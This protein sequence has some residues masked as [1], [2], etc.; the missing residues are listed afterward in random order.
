MKKLLQKLVFYAMKPR[1]NRLL[2]KD[3]LFIAHRGLHNDIYPENSIG[4]FTNAINNN[5][6]I[7]LDV[8]KTKDD[9]LVVFHDDSL[10]RM[11][12]VNQYIEKCTYDELQKFYLKNTNYK[13]PLFEDV[14]KL[15]DGK[16][17]LIIEV[18]DQKLT[19][20]KKVSELVAEMLKNYNGEFLIE[21]FNPMVLYWFRRNCPDIIRA[22]LASNL[23][24]DDNKKRYFIPKLLASNM[25]FNFLS[26]PDLISYNHKY[27]DSFVVKLCEKLYNADFM[28]WT[29]TSEKDFEKFKENKDCKMF[30]FEDINDNFMNHFRFS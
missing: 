12:G 14:L 25:F 28:M 24:K 16:V 15:V 17:V 26:K 8:H 21:S 20:Y 3:N 9:K 7:E 4:A 13:I 18:K 27:S 6:G 1:K 29:L 2:L 10:L 19:Q 5:Y 23:F 30:I 11:C 22:Q